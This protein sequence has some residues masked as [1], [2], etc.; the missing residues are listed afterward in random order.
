MRIYH[1]FP[2]TDELVVTSMQ[3]TGFTL[4]ECRFSKVD[5]PID[6]AGQALSNIKGILFV[7]AKATYF[8]F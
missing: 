4:L 5:A 2:V 7:V 8:W 3:Q 1:A 6:T